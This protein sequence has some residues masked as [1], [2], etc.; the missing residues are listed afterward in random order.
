MVPQFFRLSKLCLITTIMYSTTTATVA[1]FF[2]KPRIRGTY[3]RIF[4]RTQTPNSEPCPQRLIHQSIGFRNPTSDGWLIPHNTIKHD[5]E[6][7]SRS[8]ALVLESFNSSS[9][10]PKYLNRGNRITRETFQILRSQSTIFWMGIDV[11]LCG[12]FLLPFPTY[13]FFVREGRHTIMTPFRVS[14]APKIKYMIV[15]S[16]SFSCIYEHIMKEAK[17]SSIPLVSSEAVA[18]SVPTFTSLPSVTMAPSQ[19]G[20][21]ISAIPLPS[22]STPSSALVSSSPSVSLSPLPRKSTRPAKTSQGVTQPPSSGLGGEALCFPGDAMV[23]MSNNGALKMIK[24]VTVGDSVSVGHGMK[25]EVFTFS[26][27]EPEAWTQFVV[28][29]TRCNSKVLLTSG[30]FLYV[31]GQLRQAGVVQVGD[32]LRVSNGSWCDVI[33]VGQ[34]RRMGLFNPHTVHGDLVI[35]GVFT[36]SY[37]SFIKPQ[38][39]HALLAPVRGVWK[40]ELT[41]W[42][43]KGLSWIL[44]RA[45]LLGFWRCTLGLLV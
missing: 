26:H 8:G 17:E 21:G 44:P 37:T 14:L 13:V 40:L 35:D 29:W 27:Y 10:T 9:L 24:D 20:E 28:I 30:H 45:F 25:S 4:E 36:S 42:T 39:A 41:H 38:S 31:N 32:F 1:H 5:K 6:L 12:R 18:S 22:T 43:H 23:H 34:E 3:G 15:M 33:K 11:R 19:N 16:T 7:C 2:S